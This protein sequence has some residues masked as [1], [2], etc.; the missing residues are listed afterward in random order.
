MYSRCFIP[1]AV[2]MRPV[3]ACARLTSGQTLSMAT[4]RSAGLTPTTFMVKNFK[5]LTSDLD[6]LRL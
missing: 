3:D 2:L 1:T 4:L 5:K 6:E